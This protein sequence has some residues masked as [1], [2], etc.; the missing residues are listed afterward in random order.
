MNKAFTRE[1][2]EPDELHCPRCGALGSPVGAATIAAHLGEGARSSLSSTV[3]FCPTPTCPVAYFDHFEQTIA[4]SD[5]NRAVYPKD[6]QAPI[7]A[8]FKLKADDVEADA[9]AGNP[10]G[11]RELIRMSQTAA[12]RCE[13]LA[14]SGKCCVPE[15]QKLYMRNT[16]KAAT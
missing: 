4:A 12:A 10:A 8:C 14:A 7:C 16:P 6:P 1:P 11:V 5:L 9:Q 2:D 13:T 3:C 15:V